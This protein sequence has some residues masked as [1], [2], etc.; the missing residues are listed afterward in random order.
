[1]KQKA[2]I[3]LA[4]KINCPLYKSISLT[5]F[6]KIRIRMRRWILSQKDYWNW[7]SYAKGS[8]VSVLMETHGDVVWTEDIQKVME[9]SI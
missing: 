8:N 4:Q 1:M 9:I 2:F 3:D 5:T 6:R 7:A